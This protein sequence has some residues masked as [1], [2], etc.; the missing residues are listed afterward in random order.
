MAQINKSSEYFNTKLWT[1]DGSDDRNITGVGFQPDLTWIKVRSQ[2]YNHYV[3]DG[4]RGATKRIV[5]NSTEAE[6]TQANELQAFLSDGFQI[7]SDAGMNQNTDTYASWNWLADNTSGS[8]N[9]DGSIT[10]TVSAS[11]VSGFSIVSY[12]GNATAGATIGHG[13]G[14]TPKMI[15]V[16]NRESVYDWRVYHQSLGSTKYLNLN[17]NGGFGTATSIWNDTDPTSSVFS[18]GDSPRVNESGIDFIAYC[19]AE[20]KGFSKFGS[21]TGNGSDDG[22]FVYLGFK[23]SFVMVK[24]TDNTRNWTIIDNK[25]NTF[26]PETQWLYPNTSDIE[27]TASSYPVDFVSNGFKIRTGAASY[28]NTSGENYIYMAFAENPLVGTNNIP[29]TAR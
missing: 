4:V 16:K 14:S 29:A 13:L 9:T 3:F 27:L 10:S 21:Y 11:T 8:S 12:T 22:T 5:P 26:N 17:T 7:G 2:A 25:R 19:F 28:F 15:I 23:P 20:K 24:N 18:I 6:S 1:G